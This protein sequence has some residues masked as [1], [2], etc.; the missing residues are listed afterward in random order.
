[1]KSQ[2]TTRR[3]VTALAIIMAAAIAVAA[4]APAALADASAAAK[5]EGEVVIATA[6]GMLQDAL[7]KHLYDNFTKTTGI[8]V[9]AVTINPDEQWTKIKADT[10]A[11]G[12]K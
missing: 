8:K 12:V 1:M 9:T 2:G 5:A 3:A 6:G 11:G 7:A 10:E 4:R